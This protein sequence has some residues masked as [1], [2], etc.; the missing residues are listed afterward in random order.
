M[1]ITRTTE[2]LYILTNGPAVIGWVQR[3]TRGCWR[4][5][6]PAGALTHHRTLTEAVEAIGGQP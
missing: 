6:T 4:A 3:A 2:G 1:T 5:L